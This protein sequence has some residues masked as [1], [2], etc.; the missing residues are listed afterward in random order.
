VREEKAESCN[1][2]A[3][4]PDLVDWHCWV[5]K[6]APKEVKK[7]EGGAITIG[8]ERRFAVVCETTPRVRAKHP[9]WKLNEFADIAIQKKR[10]RLTGWIMFDPAHSDQLL[11]AEIQKP[12]RATLW[13]VHPLTKV[14]VQEDGSWRDLDG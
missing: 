12:T 5:T 3:I 2:G 10:V 13:E 4:A 1:C 6:S 11:A 8:D 9:K 7:A 14:E